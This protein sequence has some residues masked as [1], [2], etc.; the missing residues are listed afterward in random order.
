MKKQGVRKFGG[1]PIFSLLSFS[2]A[3]EPGRRAVLERAVSLM[4]HVGGI[5]GKV[6]ALVDAELVRTLVQLSVWAQLGVL[7]RE[8]LTRFF[9]NGCDG[10]SWGPCCTFRMSQEGF[11]CSIVCLG[12][13]CLSVYLSVAL[14]VHPSISISPWLADL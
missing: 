9:V 4:G 2:F 14:S 8:Y 6:G 7:C 1:N 5:G 12:S 13:V 10:V 3:R 11:A